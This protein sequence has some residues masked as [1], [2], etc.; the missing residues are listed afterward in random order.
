M[1]AG[2]PSSAGDTR[3]SDNGAARCGHTSSSTDHPDGDAVGPPPAE[4]SV[5]PKPE[6]GEPAHH[7]TSGQPYSQNGGGFVQSRSRR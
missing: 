5:P 7:A 4:P 3:P 1:D 2:L 6:A